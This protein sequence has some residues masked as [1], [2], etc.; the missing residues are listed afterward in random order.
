MLTAIVLT[1]LAVL[2]R[3]FSS[4]WQ[5]WNFAPLGAVSLFAGSRLPRRWAW[6]VP[7]AAMAISDY[8]I[9]HDRYRPLF[10]LTRWTIYATF[11]ATTLLGPSGQSAQVRPMAASGPLAE[12]LDALFP[13][14]QPGHVGRRPTLPHDVLGPDLVLH[15]GDSVLRQYRRR[16][17]A[18]HGSSFRPGAN[19]RAGRAACDT[20]AAGRDH[21]RSRRVRVRPGPRDP[22]QTNLV[23]KLLVS[24]RS[25]VEA[26]AALAGGAAI[27]DVKEPLNGPLGRAHFAVWHEVRERRP[28]PSPVSV[29][30][31][32]L[33]DWPGIDA[34]EVPR[35]DLDG[36][37]LLQA[38]PSHAP[39]DWIDR[40]RIFGNAGGF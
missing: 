30:L 17:S 23:A 5:V 1:V 12:R 35:G 29:A 24:V 10:E 6:V 37:G 9:D 27:I 28:P 16:R 3:V 18:G 34:V 32:E 15:P 26:L 31:G 4:T 33:N 14:E 7:I 11:A 22:L 20:T 8:L 21:E 36:P 39:P 38:R 2:F 19:L 13:D 40:W 25:K